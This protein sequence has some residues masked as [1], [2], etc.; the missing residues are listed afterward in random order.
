[1]SRPTV[2][3]LPLGRAGG[4]PASEIESELRRCGI[5][6]ASPEASE[7]NAVVVVFE[8]GDDEVVR[9]V[10]EL[11][12]RHPCLMLAVATVRD[13]LHQGTVWRLIQAGA[14]DVLVWSEHPALA[15][16][17]AERIQRSRE[18]D[19]LCQS[20][21][22][23]DSL[24]GESPSWR[25]LMHQVVEAARFT[26]SS[27][28]IA[29]ETG[30]GKELLAR[31]VHALDARPGKGPFVVVD[32][33]T[34]VPELA[35]SELFGH[36]RG[37]FTHAVAARDGAFALADGGTLFLDEVGELPPVLQAEL[38]RAVQE[39]S[40]KRVGSNVWQQT[41]FRL[42]CA[43]NRDLVAASVR[44]R[45]R[46]DLY[47]RIATWTLQAPPLRER[48]EDIL[49]LARHF[50]AAASEILRAAE[51]VFDPTVEEFLLTRPYRGNVR[52]LR[53]LVLRMVARH[54]GPGPVTVGSIPEGDRLEAAR[55]LGSD[56]TSGDLEVALRRALAGGA[57]LQE[58]KERT[59]DTAIGIALRDARGNVHQAALRLRVTDRAVQ[60]RRA[61]RRG[62]TCG[63]VRQLT[64]PE[65]PQQVPTD[66]GAPPPSP[67][68]GE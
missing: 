50:A 40:F 53:Q 35:G 21:T 44:G 48:R 39:R 61:A 51:T 5:G 25:R 23:R 10:H 8:D 13:G 62:G 64:A 1:M 31:L 38:L 6:I 42:I 52:E 33:T 27:L 32:C 4:P 20:P 68:I 41:R 60:M 24:V 65:F 63:M 59:A 43:T 28:L 22:V 2:C 54:V 56:W 7:A 46:L 57:G 3:I 47:H 17:L 37:A 12:A 14:A 16:A 29:G 30:T 55:E 36:E 15:E 26:G 67:R 58:I 49:P 9:R 19:A 34:V 18:V 66:P 45:F 11:A